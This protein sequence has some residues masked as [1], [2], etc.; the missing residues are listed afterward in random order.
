MADTSKK[1]HAHE[2]KRKLHRKDLQQ[3]KQSAQK[4]QKVTSWKNLL[5]NVISETAELLSL[6]NQSK[7][8]YN[9]RITFAKNQKELNPSVFSDACI[10]EYERFAEEVDQL[11]KTV[12]LLV[13]MTATMED[14]ADTRERM[15]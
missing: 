13:S 5:A 14:M 6:Y 15:E 12:R 11:G 1:R 9:N 8:F 7:Q 2:L 4:P 10:E 3:K